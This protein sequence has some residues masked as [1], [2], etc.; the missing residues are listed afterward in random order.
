M[1]NH[2]DTEET[3][4]LYRA[5]PINAKFDWDN[6]PARRVT[7]DADDRGLEDFDRVL[8]TSAEFNSVAPPGFEPRRETGDF[9][10]WERASGQ[11]PAQGEPG[12]R[13]TLLEPIYPGATL[14][15]SEESGRGLSQV[16]GGS[17]VVFRGRRR[18]ARPGS[19]AP[20]SPTPPARSRS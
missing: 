10:L 6:V 11:T 14:D 7:D 16:E 12:F 1:V 15:C 5:T 19:P 18:S 8:T 20:T 13:R 4:T 2:Y 3:S 9:I 17:A